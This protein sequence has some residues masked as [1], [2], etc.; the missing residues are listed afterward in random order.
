MTSQTV[1]RDDI[2]MALIRILSV[3]GLILSSENMSTA[4]RRERIRVTIMER[5]CQHGMFNEELTY[6]QAYKRCYGQSVE[7]RKSPRPEA[8]GA[9]KEGV[10]AA[11]TDK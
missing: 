7:L 6:A 3:H 11:E 4:D 5:K 10:S 8:P 2:E 9:A 1:E